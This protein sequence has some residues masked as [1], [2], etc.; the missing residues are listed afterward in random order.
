LFL[1]KAVNAAVLHDLYTREGVLTFIRQNTE[2]LLMAA[3]SLIAEESHIEL[4]LRALKGSLS[5]GIP[6]LVADLVKSKAYSL[7]AGRL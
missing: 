1:E 3:P 5:R 2:V 7:F 4:F 6:A